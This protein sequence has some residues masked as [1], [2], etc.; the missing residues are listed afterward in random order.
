MSPG[1]GRETARRLLARFGSPQAVFEQTATTLRELGSDFLARI[2]PV[3]V[4]AASDR[5]AAI[6]E[7]VGAGDPTAVAEA[8]HA[9]R[10]SAANLGGK[11]VAAVCGRIE[12][13]ASAT[14]AQADSRVDLE[15]LETE[16]PQMIDAV[17]ALVRVPA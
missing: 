15:Q 6:R 13:A 1:V 2:V 9:L 3:F 11:R 16:L 7:A 8:A 5:L 10:G 4:L 14:W 12:E 17:E